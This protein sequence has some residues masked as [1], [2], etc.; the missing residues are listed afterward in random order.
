MS[1]ASHSS[2]YS[3]LLTVSCRHKEIIKINMLCS[4]QTGNSH[5]QHSGERQKCIKTFDYATKSRETNFK[6]SA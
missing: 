5:M 1:P 3:R 6:M 2:L 4:V